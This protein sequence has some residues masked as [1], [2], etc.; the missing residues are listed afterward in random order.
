METKEVGF[1]TFVTEIESCML[2]PLVYT[3]LGFMLAAILFILLIN[4]IEANGFNVKEN[5]PIQPDSV[6]PE[7]HPEM[8]MLPDSSLVP[9]SSIK[10]GE[11]LD[12]VAFSEEDTLFADTFI[13]KNDYKLILFPAADGYS[14]EGEVY[15]GHYARLLG[16]SI[17]EVILNSYGTVPAK[18]WLRYDSIDFDDC[19]AIEYSGGGNYSMYIHL[20]DKATGNLLIA[21]HSGAT[22]VDNGLILYLDDEEYNIFLYDVKTKE[23]IEIERPDRPC[24]KGTG[25][26]TGYTITKVTPGMVYLRYDYCEKPVIIK[27]KR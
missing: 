10:W 17:D 13:L 8:L 3:I 26:W 23:R 12:Y 6:T 4:K 21:G 24:F 25:H 22:D 19:F 7:E 1:C 5:F 27:V 14:E 15:F 18:Y 16:D 11:P 2:K 9:F 20:Y